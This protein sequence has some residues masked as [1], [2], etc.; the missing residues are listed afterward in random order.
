M[1]KL[2]SELMK[3]FNNLSREE[4]QS[5]SKASNSKNI[6]SNKSNSSEGSS[7]NNFPSE[8]QKNTKMFAYSKNLKKI[9][10]ESQDT[11][12]ENDVYGQNDLKDKD[13]DSSR[14]DSR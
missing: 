13:G 3:E 10:R 6:S 4:E 14:Y 5:C 9:R 1:I 2:V 11:D 7:S 12:D 8:P